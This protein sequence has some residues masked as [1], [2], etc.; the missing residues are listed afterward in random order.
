MFLDSLDTHGHVSAEG[1]QVKSRVIDLDVD[2]GAD[3][4][5]Y[6]YVEAQYYTLIS[7]LNSLSQRHCK[8]GVAFRI[9]DR[10]AEAGGYSQ[11][12]CGRNGLPEEA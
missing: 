9:G 3:A 6:K 8:S 10:N 12:N 1:G 5:D 2:I 7:S 4:V 11:G